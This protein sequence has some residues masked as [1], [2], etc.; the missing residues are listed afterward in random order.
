MLSG[1]FAGKLRQLD[2]HFRVYCHSNP[3]LPAGLY[4]EDGKDLVHICG[5]D[6]SEVP[7]FTIWNGPFILKS[8]WR[9]TLKILV[10]KQLV[11]KYKVAKVFGVHLEYG[12]RPKQPRWV[13]PIQ[14][15]LKEAYK[16]GAK[17]SPG[18]IELDDLLQIHRQKGK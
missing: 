3:N 12:D 5:V 4:Y 17:K 6:R 8:G 9:R 2:P 11:T 13:N 10:G 18:Y 7:E 14:E 1:T 15:A 16:Q